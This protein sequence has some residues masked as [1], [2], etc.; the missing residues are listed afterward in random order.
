MSRPLTH[1]T[2]VV[3]AAGLFAALLFSL[4]GAPATLAQM[5]PANPD[6]PGSIAG[7][8]TNE[9]GAAVA[10]AEV[11]LFRQD[12]YGWP[13]VQASTSISA[14]LARRWPI[15]RWWRGS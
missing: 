9:E 12:E 1:I 5:A 10:D 14:S 4:A 15:C 7:V 3:I 8:I 13:L 2:A 6:A 11:Q